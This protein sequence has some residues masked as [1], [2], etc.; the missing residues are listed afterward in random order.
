MDRF[1]KTPTQWTE[2]YN[3]NRATGKHALV[4]FNAGEYAWQV[5]RTVLR[6]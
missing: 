5:R 1:S 6:G 4:A 2:F 3:I